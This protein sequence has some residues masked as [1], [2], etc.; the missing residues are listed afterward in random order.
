MAGAV[1]GALRVNLGLDSAAFTKGVKAV[2]GM[3]GRVQQSFERIGK[4]ATDLGKRLSVVSAGMA[5]AGAAGLALAN[6]ISQVGVEIDRFSKLANAAPRDFQRWSSGSK[7]VGIGQDKLADILKDVNDRVGDFLTTGGGPMKDFFE[8]IA[9]KVG[10][11][12]EQFRKLSGPDALQLYVSSMQKAGL[13]QQEM[14]F[15]MEA[16]ASDSTLLLPL[17][18]NNGKAM[19][20]LGDAAEKSGAVM[21]DKAVAASVEFQNKVRALGEAVT[22]L[23]YRLAEDLLPIFTKLV[24]AITDKVIPVMA[25]M[26]DKIGEWAERFGELPGPVQDAAAIIAATLGTAGP[27]LL[28]LGVLSTKFA[29]LIAATGPI[30]LFVAIATTAAAAWMVW[31][32]DIKAAVGGAI[33]YVSGKFQ[34]LLDFLQRIIDKAVQIKDSIRDALF[35]GAGKEIVPADRTHGVTGRGEPTQGYQPAPRGRR[36]PRVA[37]TGDETAAGLV[38]GLSDGINARTGDISAAVGV[39]TDTARQELGIQSPSKVFREIGDWIA[40]GLSIGITDGVPGVK[41]AA[42]GLVDAVEGKAG[43]LSDSMRSFQATAK[44]AFQDVITNG[45]KVENALKSIA[46]QWLSS[47]ASGLFSSGFDALWKGIGLPSFDGGGYTWDGPRSGGLDGKG[48]RLAM[49]HPRET[50]LDH[51][52]GQGVAGAGGGVITVE[53]APNPY[54]D[55]RVAQVSGAGDARMAQVQQRAMPGAIRDMQARGRR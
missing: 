17:L 3:T 5:A 18:L 19:R 41:V 53:A 11:T 12:A 37:D 54:F 23:Q 42:D 28:A 33:D 31:G 6:R 22:G 25:G 14:T 24:Q 36:E 29:A 13:S 48:G 38:Q 27:I 20:D 1:I 7:S 40:Q 8:Q 52:K 21:S 9:P 44:M 34:G 45:G 10:V 46:A 51:T 55:L 30:G 16:M 43:S 35:A 4:T 50:V 2:Q 39:V 26:V 15:F 49:L 32:D 47:R